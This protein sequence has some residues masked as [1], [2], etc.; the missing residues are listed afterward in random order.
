[1]TVHHLRPQFTD[2]IIKTL[3]QGTSVNLIA[4][5]GQG[6]KRLLEDI[7]KMRLE[8]TQIFFV[9]MKNY[10][11]NYQ[12]FLKECWQQFGKK[13]ELPTDLGQLMTLL[14]ETNKKFILL[15]YHFD[16]LLNNARIDP[17]F[18]VFFFDQLNSL[19]DQENLSLLCVTKHPHDQSIIFIHQKIHSHSWLD[20]EKKRVPK[21][22]YDEILY[23]LKTRNL[24]LSQ[25]ELSEIA[26]FVHRNN[27]PYWV[28]NYFADKL[29]H[30][31]NEEIELEHRLKKWY[32][33]FKKEDFIWTTR[34]VLSSKEQLKISFK[35]LLNSI[36]HFIKNSFSTKKPF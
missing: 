27:K 9:N 12:G 4:P 36:L 17:K 2:N 14:E 13:G 8:N 23:E 31:D 32:R 15:L 28:L 11:E 20:L 18:D 34:E 29:K 5:S 7:K 1:M 35:L 33:Q 19:K 22:T 3:Q 30:R 10:K 6:R 21:L 26:W 25:D 16:D 24:S